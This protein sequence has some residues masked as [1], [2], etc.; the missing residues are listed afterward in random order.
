MEPWW[1][2]VIGAVAFFYIQSYNR[3][4]RMYFESQKTLSWNDFFTKVVPVS[5]N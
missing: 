5:G 1:P 3:V 2:Y 4:A